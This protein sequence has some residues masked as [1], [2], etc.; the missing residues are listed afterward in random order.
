MTVGGSG[1][2]KVNA[3]GVILDGVTS[4]EFVAGRVALKM[5]FDAE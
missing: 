4:K 5:M 2:D 3:G 1:R